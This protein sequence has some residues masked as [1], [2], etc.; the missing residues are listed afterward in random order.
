MND[1]TCP[2]LG[3]NFVREN[4][5]DDNIH[6]VSTVMKGEIGENISHETNSVIPI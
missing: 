2:N 4:I 3:H 1:E 5:I 6:L